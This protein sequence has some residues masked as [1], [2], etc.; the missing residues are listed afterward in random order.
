MS[1]FCLLL[2]LKSLQLFLSSSIHECLYIYHSIM[3]VCNVMYS[4][5]IVSALTGA[6]ISK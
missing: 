1:Y 5:M 4:I 2:T 6:V 3:N